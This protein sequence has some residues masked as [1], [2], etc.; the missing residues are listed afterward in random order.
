MST[1]V[2]YTSIKSSV[3][4]FEGFKWHEIEK[5]EGQSETPY[6]PR[7]NVKNYIKYKG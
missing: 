5:Y 7:A 2:T 1:H 6:F 4:D 3:Q